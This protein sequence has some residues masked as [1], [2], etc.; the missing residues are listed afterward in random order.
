MTVIYTISAPDGEHEAVGD[1]AFDTVIDLLQEKF[2]DHELS[3]TGRLID[4]RM[5]QS[6]R[7]STG[8][9]LKEGAA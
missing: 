1:N 5:I 2:P 6:K 7:M 8:P 4:D 9:W 3:I